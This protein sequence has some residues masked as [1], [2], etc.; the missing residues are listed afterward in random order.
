MSWICQNCSTEIEPQ[1][2]VCWNCGTDSRGRVDENFARDSDPDDTFD[3]PEIPRICCDDC[4]Y[5]GKVLFSTEQKSGLEWIVAG[6]LSIF[7][8]QR[9]W[10]HFCHKLCPKCGS[11]QERHRGWS[12][13]ISEQHNA[14]WLAASKREELR[15]RKNRLL[16]Y[17][18]LAS[19]LTASLILWWSL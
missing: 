1:F 19:I 11:S 13:E 2:K 18:V 8:S 15:T 10:V 12:G 4:G 3:E 7:I 14:L 17:F 9:S 6:L 16:F 5:Q